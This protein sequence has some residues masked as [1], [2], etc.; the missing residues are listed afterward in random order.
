MIQRESVLPDKIMMTS[1]LQAAAPDGA[2]IEYPDLVL[3]ERRDVGL[4]LVRGRRENPEFAA[5][6]KNLFGA[7]PPEGRAS[8]PAGAFSIVRMGRTDYLV[9]GELEVVEALSRRAEAA[10][11]G[12][13]CI[14]A[15]ITHGRFIVDMKGAGAVTALSKSCGLDMRA[16][17]FPIGLG[18]RTR[19]ADSLAYVERMGVD[20][21]R[22][23]SDRS[24]AVFVWSWLK[25]A[26]ADATHADPTPE[27]PR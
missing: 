5:W 3:T 14:A 24:S 16:A 25:D 15:E 7:A 21:F 1:P 27:S 4:L 23:I 9:S 8:V 11:E 19:F 12:A 26:G 20:A 17:A 22:L 6:F 13:P 2:V 18:T 10:A